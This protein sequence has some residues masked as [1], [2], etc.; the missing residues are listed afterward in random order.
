MTVPLTSPPTENIGANGIPAV[1]S[2]EVLAFAAEHQAQDCLQPLL[3]VTHRIFPTARFV[4]V[5]VADDPEL[6]DNRQILFHVQVAGLSLDE[7][8]TA[9]N[10]W[11]QE[12]FRICPPLRKFLFCLLLDL[13]S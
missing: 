10:R 11:T 6:H 5:R 3:E 2:T 8:R 4:R 9:D 12:F 13:K 7:A 1:F